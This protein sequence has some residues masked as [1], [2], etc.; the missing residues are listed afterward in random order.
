MKKK[1]ST[2][3][4][5]LL[6][7]L[8]VGVVF[9]QKATVINTDTL[10][11]KIVE[12]G[13]P[14]AF[15]GG[16][17]LETSY[18]YVELKDDVLGFSVVTDYQTTLSSSMTASQ[19]TVPVSKV[20]T[21]DDHTL[22]MSDLGEKV[23]FIIEPGASKQEIVMCTGL[24]GTTWTTCTRGLAFYGTSTASVSGNRKTHNSGST[25]VMS[26]VHYVYDEQVDKD[27]DETI[28]GIKTFTSSPIVPSPTTDLQVA[29]KAYVDN[30]AIAGGAT[31]TETTLGLSQ[32]GTQSEMAST[33]FDSN[34]PQVLSTKYST[35]SSPTS[36]NYAVIS[37]SD[38][39]IDQGWIDLTEDFE[40]TGDVTIDDRVIS[41]TSLSIFGGNGSDGVLNIT[42]G[43]TSI[44]ASSE[45]VVR[46]EYSSINISAGAVLNLTNKASDGTLLILKSLGDVTIAGD[47]NL[48]GQ[49]ANEQTNAF[50]I[51][52]SETNHDGNN[53][54]NGD[55]GGV[56]KAGGT[57]GVIYGNKVFY[58]TADE[59]R[60]YRKFIEI[61]VGSGGGAGGN[62]YTGGGGAAGGVGGKGG[63]GLII[64]CAGS[65][66]FSG[67]INVNGENGSD[68][69]DSSGS[70][71]GGAGGGGGGTAGMALV[72]YNSLTANTGT[73]TAKGGAGGNGGDSST[74][75]SN[76]AGAGGGGG[77]GS[78]TT[79]GKT[80]GAGGNA[81]ADG[82]AGTNTTDAS[83]AG[84][85]GGAGDGTQTGGVGG[86]QGA[87]D[88]N[89]YLIVKNTEF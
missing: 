45:N 75:E 78:Y 37:E 82:N 31:S 58:V 76:G 14:S 51:L 84:G 2:L 81:G 8:P 87:N 20:T 59:K 18:G 50:E 6:L 13:D 66:N 86:T 26:N 61:V 77:G 19:S 80:G 24:T 52:D 23:F 70:N 53:G 69:N 71:S 36:G 12:V 44:D 16:Y 88:T 83:G 41:S 62:E 57:G 30:V 46:K 67:I 5:M 54:V 35:S 43:T 32:L 47:I 56:G 9:A 85:G 15:Y 48:E 68:G 40:F 3:L 4:A 7:L 10:H 60:M 89:H 72:L 55:S 29:T 27:S 22:T 73:T 63:G 28:A 65:L 1:L 42:T 17:S 11:R 38:G 25:I 74:G 21:K 39:N 79:A 34:N 64:E 49:G 33:T